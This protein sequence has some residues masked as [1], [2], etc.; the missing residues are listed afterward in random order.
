MAEPVSVSV[1][2]EPATV[3]PHLAFSDGAPDPRLV[4]DKALA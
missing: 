3:R 1:P 4:P 2:P